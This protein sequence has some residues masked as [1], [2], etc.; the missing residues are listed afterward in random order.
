MIFV[1]IFQWVCIGFRKLDIMVWKLYVEGTPNMQNNR[2][3]GRLSIERRSLIVI[4][5]WEHTLRARL[6]A[7]MVTIFEQCTFL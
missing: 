1:G 3:V 4:S 7:E 6:A 5:L 2:N